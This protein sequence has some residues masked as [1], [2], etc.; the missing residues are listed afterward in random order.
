MG[1]MGGRRAPPTSY[2]VCRCAIQTCACI[3]G[4][5]R[6]VAALVDDVAELLGPEGDGPD[7]AER[8]PDELVFGRAGALYIMRIVRHWVPDCADL[9]DTALE[10]LA[11]RLV[12]S[13]GG[14]TFQ[15][16]RFL[17]IA[18]GDMGIITQVVLSVPSLAP[19]LAGRVEALLDERTADGNWPEP[20]LPDIL[21]G[22]V[23]FCYGA[24]GFVFALQALRPFFPQLR[25]RFDEAID[26]AR[27]VT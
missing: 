3:T 9:V 8:F 2:C 11:S 16:G 6:H 4:D 24:P 22:R 17:G 19:R 26:R 1:L 13:D 15:G 10:Q 7:G 27:A 14:W 21:G 18:H 25:D 23:Q 20:V 12:S 5:R